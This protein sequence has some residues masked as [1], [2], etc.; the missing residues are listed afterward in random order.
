MTDKTN[1]A[2][3]VSDPS[4]PHYD[5]HSPYYELTA[6]PSSKY[7][8]GPLRSDEMHSGGEIRDEANQNADLQAILF[9]A[10]GMNLPPKLREQYAQELYL[11]QIGESGQGLRDG[12]DMRTPGAPPRTRWENAS[13]EQMVRAISEDANAP[14][15]A[16]SAEEWVRAGGELTEHQRSLAEAI[17]ASAADWKGEGGDAVR[18]HMANV[19]KWLGTT[20]QGATLSGRQQEIHSQALDQTQQAMGANP[21]VEFS[22]RSANARLQGITDPVEYARQA[23]QASRTYTEQQAAREQAAQIMTRYDQTIGSA[24]ATPRFAAPPKLATALRA[25]RLMPSPTAR[26]RTVAGDLIDP[27]MR[28]RSS[29]PDRRDPRQLSPEEGTP[30]GGPGDP[31]GPAPRGDDGRPPTGGPGDG[32]RPS[33]QPPP[34]PPA[35]SPGSPGGGGPGGAPFSPPPFVPPGGT[36]HGGN[37]GSLPPISLPPGDT[38]KPSSTTHPSFVPPPLSPPGGEPLGGNPG[39]LP[40]LSPPSGGP[41]GSPLGNPGGLPPISLPP[42]GP[43]GRPGGPGPRIPPLKLPDGEPLG[44]SGPGSGPGGGS[45][46]GK[47][48]TIGRGG[49]I[50]GESI[51]S[52]LGGGGLGGAAGGRGGSLSGGPG[53]GA[54]VPEEP[55]PGRG[56]AAGAGAKGTPGSPGMNGMGGGNKGGKG[57]EDKEHKIA[58]YVE[59]DDP[60]FFS[61]DEVVAP[62]VIGD[63]KNTDWK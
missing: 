54:G 45:G 17:T 25:D 13:H 51:G 28:G 21:P 41:V 6:D 50:N 20:A 40:P 48:P 42:G 62:P 22:V 7:Y 49:G 14:S 44:G 12:L 5:P 2:A 10:I 39:R 18:E 27:D 43:S 63:W 60:S 26:G 15:V 19:G 36:P 55:V 34:A 23:V 53:T 56:G 3:D 11:R 35:G 47:V 4:S 32:V 29:V 30:V 31:G 59:S 46:S 33:F 37:P 61:A 8:V 57:P 16:E 24:V 1:S 58:D 9:G 38:T 52:R